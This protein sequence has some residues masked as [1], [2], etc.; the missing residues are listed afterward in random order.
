MRSILAI[1]ICISALASGLMAE[2]ADRELNQMVTSSGPSAT[3]FATIYE[4]LSTRP[5]LSTIK[6]LFGSPMLPKEILASLNDSATAGTLFF[7]TDA[8]FRN[9]PSAALTWLTSSSNSD[10]LN[11]FLVYLVVPSGVYKYQDGI[12][13]VKASGGTSIELPTGFVYN[14]TTGAAYPIIVSLNK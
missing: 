2:G 1:S 7:P 14:E 9:L 8:A 6:Q 5:E 13:A 10:F 11:A 4:C 12:N 3:S